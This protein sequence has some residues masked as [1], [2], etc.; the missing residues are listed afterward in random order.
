MAQAYGKDNDL[1][2]PITVGIKMKPLNSFVVGLE[3]SAKHSFSENLDGSYPEF[4]DSSLYSQRPFGSNLS[5]D[6][7]VYSGI[8]LTIYLEIMSATVPDDILKKIN[9]SKIPNHVAVIMDGNGRWA[10]KIG[11]ERFWT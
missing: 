4:D 8:T 11:K 5:Q 2:L 9:K 3:I 10:K 1:A 7:Y 6:W